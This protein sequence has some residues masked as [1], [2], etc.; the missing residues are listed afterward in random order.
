MPMSR[1]LRT[2]A[3][4]HTECLKDKRRLTLTAV[5]TR[6]FKEMSN[7]KILNTGRTWMLQLLLLE[8]SKVVKLRIMLPVLNLIP[9]WLWMLN[10]LTLSIVKEMV[11]VNIFHLVLFHLK[12]S[13]KTQW[14]QHKCASRTTTP[15][16]LSRWR[17]L[18]KETCLKFR[19]FACLMLVQVLLIT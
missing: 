16:T 6:T 2:W 10:S 18:T 12:L 3:W 7:S 14:W 19:L 15:I 13:R 17:V 1:I 4:W 9:R 8:A 5:L 11:L